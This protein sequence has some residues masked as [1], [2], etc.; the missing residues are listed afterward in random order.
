MKEIK[1]FSYHKLGRRFVCKYK[2]GAWEKGKLT[3]RA[4]VVLNESACVL[5][6]AQTCFEGL[7][8][9]RTEDGHVVCFR[10]DLNET[11]LADSCRRMRMP[12]L[13]EGMFL[14]AVKRV[15]L[16]NEKHIP[17]A[18][19]GGSLYLR[20]YVFGTNAV[21][22]V[23]P[24]SE[25]QFR[26]FATPVGSYFHGG[27]SP[28]RIRI[29][30]FDRAAPHGTGH[31]KA[32]LNYAMSLYAITDA[33]EKGYDENLY[34]DAATRTYLEETGGANVIFITKDNTLVTPKSD[35]I[36]PSITRRSL[37]YVAEH[38][39]GMKTEERK[40]ALSEIGEFTECGLCG[41]AAVISPV[42]TIDDHGREVHY[43]MD[44]FEN[45]VIAKLYHTLLDIQHGKIEAP[46]G[47]IVKIK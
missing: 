25:F 45:T 9:Y 8:A 31:I 6:Y 1:G 15:V 39:L 7:K 38:Y 32:G 44:D 16:A 20:P 13:P 26:V 17:D 3:R 34:L 2:D 42:G 21:I 14:D 12:T 23:K 37:L 29:S 4:N 33:H 35:S 30:D 22:G 27:V 24:A 5:Q 10:P 46:E 11:R 40:I 41:T 47:W 19:S 28:L 43:A 18:A 36:L